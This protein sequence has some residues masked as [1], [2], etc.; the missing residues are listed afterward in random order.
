ML[1]VFL[2]NVPSTHTARS[3][4]FV[5]LGVFCI[6][7]TNAMELNALAS[8]QTDEQKVQALYTVVKQDV[9]NNVKKALL[10]VTPIEKYELLK[11][12][13]NETS[14]LCVAVHNNNPEI[15]A[16]L[17]E[18]LHPT[19]KYTL[20]KSDCKAIYWAAKKNNPAIMKQL[21]IELTSHHA[22]DIEQLSS[23][24]LWAETLGEA[25]AKTNI[26]D[27]K[28]AL[29]KID[30]CERYKILKTYSS[31]LY[32][33]L[34]ECKREIVSLLLDN[35][36]SEQNYQL[37]CAANRMSS[38]KFF[39]LNPLALDLVK[40]IF[41]P[42]CLTQKKQMSTSRKPN[43]FT[44]Q[45]QQFGSRVCLEILSLK[46]GFNQTLLA[47]AQ[48][49]NASEIVAYLAEIEHEANTQLKQLPVL[50]SNQPDIVFGFE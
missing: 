46:D 50:P 23:R 27:I 37:V 45:M 11:N 6:L 30:V 24:L 29:Q 44:A 3:W 38:D 2:V 40:T 22:R 31:A 39:L 20:L 17:L 48:A 9:P 16:L 26:D 19:Q 32:L 49:Q 18:K 43:R 14:A 25:I 41:V 8:K 34:R 33:A 47:Y 13:R 36:S 42:L 35:L 15:V 10:A 12:K 21:F 5:V 4:V 28:Q 1:P 7:K